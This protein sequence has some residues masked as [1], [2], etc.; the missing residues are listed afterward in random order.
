MQACLQASVQV[1]QLLAQIC[2]DYVLPVHA[3][4]QARV[5]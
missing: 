3:Q 1:H 4:I 2:G 5:H